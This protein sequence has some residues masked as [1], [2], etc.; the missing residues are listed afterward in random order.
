MVPTSVLCVFTE[1]LELC[2]LASTGDEH[3]VAV[4]DVGHYVV[5]DV[6]ASQLSSNGYSVGGHDEE[7][8]KM[9]GREMKREREGGGRGRGRVQSREVGE[10]G[11]GQT[12]GREG[13]KGEKDAF[14]NETKISL[15]SVRCQ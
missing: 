12:R 9:G 1:V 7:R 8:E 6:G 14:Q 13:G 15:L 11:E 2:G 4:Y 3:A 5:G 10:D